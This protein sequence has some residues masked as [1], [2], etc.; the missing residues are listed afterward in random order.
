MDRPAEGRSYVSE[1]PRAQESRSPRPRIRHGLR[2]R[3]RT[4]LRAVLLSAVA[5]VAVGTAGATVAGAVLLSQAQ[6][7]RSHLTAAR[8]AAGG[9][10]GAVR[11]QDAERVQT[12][13]TQV[14]EEVRAAAGIIDSPLWAAAAV[15]P[16]VGPNVDAVR[17]MTRAAVI[18]DERALPA[19]TR[20]MTDLSS[21]SLSTDGAGIDL[22]PL[23]RAQESLPR[24]ASAVG[25]AD[26]L[27]RG[28]DTNAVLPEVAD[29]AAGFAD[30]IGAV[31]PVLDDL[32]A[33]LPAVLDMAGADGPR[34]YLVV[35][36][37]NAEIRATGGNPSAMSLLRVDDGRADLDEQADSSTFYA[38]DLV[39]SDIIEPAAEL[40]ALYE[41]DTWQF[42]QNYTRTP[43]FPLTA[44]MFDALWT[45]GTGNSV[46]GVIS[47]DPVALAHVL[48]VTGP[49]ALPDGGVISSDT[50]VQ[51][52]LHDTYE[53]FGADGGAADRYF[54]QVVRSVFAVL[55]RG[56]WAPVPMIEALSRGVAEH[57]VLAWMRDDEA[58]E[59]VARA[60]MAGTF[61]PSGDDV[62][63]FLN[64]SSHS[65]LEYYLT[66]SVT[67]S[68]DAAAGI[69]TTTIDLINSAPSEGLSPYTLGHRNRSLGL[70]GSTMLLDVVF[71]A[72]SGH[73][74]SS[75]EPPTGAV[76]AWDR[77]GV[78][79]GR[80]GRSVTVA[81]PA[82]GSASVS[83]VSS[84][85]PAVGITG[86]RTTPGIGETPVTLSGTC[87]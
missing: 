6:D 66:S 79:G 41:T 87:G 25:D 7:A 80:A 12:L 23:R 42:P 26:T 54:E 68:C 86:V 28:I 37:N 22:S 52:L 13:A 16:V 59:A 31:R 51:L 15:L 69:A 30:A 34:S 45:R 46:D 81:V 50:A 64:D 11:D 43:D 67:V 10:A 60:G 47:L 76:G 48:E 2:R 71:F 39:G 74:V 35:F 29:A 19:G 84:Y 85:D 36:Q 70:P 75:T 33:T 40:R 4:R 38:A 65:K 73:D 1:V 17:D 44:A 53:R 14:S 3:R 72:P 83:A 9:L 24:I 56:E 32:G 5:L 77:S 55:A 21:G 27:L 63:V 61:A 20:I 49:V 78:D 82:G 57:R 58:Q 62:G 18:V 8:E